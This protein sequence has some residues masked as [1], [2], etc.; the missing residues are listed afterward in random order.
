[1]AVFEIT[2]TNHQ[3]IQVELPHANAKALA[4]DLERHRCLI[5]TLVNPE[6]GNCRS[7]V[8]GCSKVMLAVEL[9]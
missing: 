8:I 7:I 4:C 6:D 3:R 9:E 5:G 1:M 2:L